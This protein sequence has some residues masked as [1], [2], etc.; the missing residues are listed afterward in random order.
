MCEPLHTGAIF[1][2]ERRMTR[3]G[4][5]PPQ[6]DI[7]LIR[8]C[9]PG[10]PSSSRPTP[11]ARQLVPQTDRCRPKAAIRHA[12]LQPPVTLSDMARRAGVALFTTRQGRRYCSPPLVIVL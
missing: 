11:L 5:E 8:D 4:A 6:V 7:P 3:P 12:R 1:F 9:K 2:F 10:A